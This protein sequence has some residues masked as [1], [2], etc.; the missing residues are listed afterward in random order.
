M[1]PARICKSNHCDDRFEREALLAGYPRVAGLDE[2]GRGCLFGPVAAAA[3]VLNL[4]AIPL[5]IDDSKKL[6]IKH[7]GKLADEIKQTAIDYAIAFVDSADVDKFNILEATREAMSRAVQGLKQ[8]PSFLLCDG[9][10]LP[11]VSI[12]QLEI[13]KGDSLSVSIAAASIIAKV[14][15]DELLDQLALEYPGYELEKNKG[16]GTARHLKALRQLGPTPLHRYTFKGVL[17][18]NLNLPFVALE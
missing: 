11:G 17:D 10:V 13:I 6:S 1:N 14:A 18:R 4:E 8:R 3:V 5:G 2:V 12:A 16:Y 7:R 15:R 9:I